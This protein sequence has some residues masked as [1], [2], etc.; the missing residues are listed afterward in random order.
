MILPLRITVLLCFRFYLNVNV[1]SMLVVRTTA[2][3]VITCQISIQT[4]EIEI[5]VTRILLWDETYCRQ[6]K[7]YCRCL[8]K[9]NMNIFHFSF[10]YVVLMYCTCIQVLH[11]GELFFCCHL[12][13]KGCVSCIMCTRHWP[14]IHSICRTISAIMQ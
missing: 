1:L 5:I 4:H 9:S 10:K 7:F 8:V 2:P 14:S 3:F 6:I 13:F 12:H 11:F